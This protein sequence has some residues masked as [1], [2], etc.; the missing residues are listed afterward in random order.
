MNIFEI[1]VS[2]NINIKISS[3][4]LVITIFA[5]LEFLVS[6]IKIHILRKELNNI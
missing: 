3:S 4:F 5:V 1:V 6:K 2:D